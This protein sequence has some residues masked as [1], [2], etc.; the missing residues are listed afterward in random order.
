MDSIEEIKKLKKEKG[1]VILS[2]NYQPPEI[3][4]IADYIGDSLA[5][6][7]A[8][9]ETDAQVIV[10][11]GVHF[12]AETASILCPD[13][14][15]LLPEIK[16]GCPMADMITPE[17]L[18]KMKATYP[19][20]EVVGYINTSAA[21][22]AEVDI[23]CTSSN[24]VKIVNAVNAEE[25][26]F[27]PDKYLADYVSKETGKKLISWDGHCPIHVSITASDINEK[28]RMHPQAEVLVHPECLPDV[29]KL[30]DK[31]LSTDGM[32]KYVH[33]TKTKE[34]II[35]TE[36]GIL[37]RLKKDAPEKMFYPASEKALCP[38]MKK[39]T[40]EKV[41]TALRENRYKINVPESIRIKAKKAIDRMLEIN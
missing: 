15:V 22:K 36:A 10:F 30:A 9:A 23:C 11:C 16:A 3:Q 25:I 13:K 17:K 8:A 14:T 27:I 37:Y 6:S 28:K 39:I 4:D 33:E 24:A 5:L 40:L 35:G 41:K 29:I 7:R 21:V 34:F 31:V 12:M 20:A 38:N 32:R 19:K 18:R 26:I 2:H 1:A